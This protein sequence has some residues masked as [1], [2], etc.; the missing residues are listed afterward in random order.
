VNNEGR[1]SRGPSHAAST[2]DLAPGAYF[3]IVRTL[4]LAFANRSLRTLC[5]S[6]AQAERHLGRAVA[7]KLR[8]R[9]SDLRA[10]TNV[11]DLI[12]GRPGEVGHGRLGHVAVELTSDSRLVFCSN[13][14]VLPVLATG[15]VDWEK[16]RRVKI[17]SI[18][19]GDG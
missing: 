9:L 4:E 19:S 15:D 7:Q 5:E 2:I 11:K 8:R 14:V 6:R 1:L 12:A 16:V 13:H 10:A 3:D 17:L 18:G